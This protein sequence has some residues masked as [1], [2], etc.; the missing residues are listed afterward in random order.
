MKDRF[1]PKAS[2]V[3]FSGC[4]G[5]GQVG[6]VADARKESSVFKRPSSSSMVCRSH[7][8]FVLPESFRKAVSLVL[9]WT[10]GMVLLPARM[11]AQEA[12]QRPVLWASSLLPAVSGTEAASTEAASTGSDTQTNGSLRRTRTVSAA[13]S[14]AADAEMLLVQAQALNASVTGSNLGSQA[15]TGPHPLSTEATKRVGAMFYRPLVGPLPAQ[16]GEGA[17]DQTEASQLKPDGMLLA[18]AERPE[19]ALSSAEANSSRSVGGAPAPATFPAGPGGVDLNAFAPPLS[20]LLFRPAMAAPPQGP[21]TI[22][23]L[24]VFVGYADDVRANPNFPVPWKGSPNT[25][26]IGG[27]ASFDAGAI[28]LDN[29]TSAPIL[30]DGVFVTVPGWTTSDHRDAQGNGIADLW[31]SFTIPPNSTVILT[32]TGEFNFD[33]SDFGVRGCGDTLA[34][35]QPPIP[36]VRVTIAGTPTTFS[37]TA[38]V[39]NTGGFD[40]ACRSNESLQW[41]LIGT[42]GIEN[43]AGHIT[44]APPTSVQPVGANYTATATVTDAG[45]QPTPNVVVNFKVL[46]GPNAGKTGTGTTDAQ[47]NATFSYTSVF[48]GTDILQASV[49]NATGGSIESEQVT[50]TWTSADACP[51]PTQPPDPAQTVLVY[52]GP[53][54]GE[55]NDPLTLAAQLTD[56]NGVPLA[57]RPLS[58][59]FGTQTFSAITDANGVAFVNI[60]AAPAPGAVPF[61]VS[62]AGESNL[63]PAQ[64]ST[65]VTIDREET[66]IR[67]T[68]GTLLGTVVPQQVS[69]VLT[70]PVGGLPIANE[71]VTFRVGTVQAQ[72]V[73]NAQGIATTTI[74]LGADQTSGPTAIQ[75]SFGGDSFYKPS[76]TG[77]PVTV[78]LSTSFVVW[79]GNPGG[80]RLGQDANFWGHSWEDQVIAGNFTANP[81][82]KGFADPV[83]QIHVCEVN[84]GSGGP[85]DDQ[86]WRSKPGNSFPPPLTLPAYIEVIISTAIAKQGSEIFGNIA[87]AAVCQVDSTPAYGPD[88]GKPGFCKLVAVVEDGANVFPQRPAL[89]ASQTQPATVLPGQNFSVTTQVTNNSPAQANSVTASESF[90]GLTPATGTQSLGSILNGAQQTATFQVATPAVPIRGSNESTVAYQQRL[91]TTDG[92]LFT[93]T[94]TITFTDAFGQQFLPIT[95]TSSSR[96][97][98]P[99]LR[100]GISGPACVGPGS[101]IP[102][103][104]TVL[105]VGTAEADNVV[106]SLNMPDGTS[107]TSTI[108]IIPAG[109]SVTT[110]INLVA[111]V[112]SAKQPNE[113]D[114]QYRAR[115][116]AVDGS[117]LIALATVNWQ[118]ALGNNYG[119]IE[120]KIVTTVERVP[121]ITVT[122]Q[123]PPTL[124][125]GQKATLNFSVQNIG[126]GNSSQVL[127]QITNPDGSLVN[128]PAFAL[129]GGQAT[130]FS[131]TFTIPGAAK[132]AGESDA[133][134]QARLAALDNSSIN[135]TTQLRWFDAAAN[136]YGPTSGGFQTTEILPL[137]TV[138]LTGPSNTFST[139]NIN[140]NLRVANIGHADAS[141]FSVIVR[142]PDGSTVNPFPA[143]PIVAGSAAQISIPFGIPQAQPTGQLTA[144]ATL[145]WTDDA[146]NPY[147]P[148]SAP[149]VTANTH[150]NLP[151]VSAGPDQSITTPSTALNGSVTISSL[152]P[153][154]TLVSSWKQISGPAPATFA[155]PSSPVTQITFTA[156]G[157]YVVELTGSVTNTTLP[158]TSSARATISVNAPTGG[159]GGGGG[160][161]GIVNQVLQGQIGQPLVGTV[162]QGQV[163][164]TVANGTTLTSGVL[165]FWPISNPSNVQVLNPNTT[166]TGVIGVFDGTTLQNG[167]YILRLTST[168]ADGT[169]QASLVTL[170][171]IGENKPGRITKTIPDLRVPVA[172]MSITINRIYDSLERGQIGDFGF[173]WKLG[174]NVQ[175]SVDSGNNVS[176]TFN[177]QRQTFFFSAQPGPFPF[178]FV[179]TPSYTPSPGF[180]GALTSDGCSPFTGAQLTCFPGGGTYHPTTFTYNDPYGRVYVFGADGSMKS[181]KDLNG[182]V[183]TFT[184]AG[185]SAGGINVAFARDA[186]GR[187]TQITDLNGKSHTYV[188]D[189]AGNLASVTKPDVTAPV[190]Y[191]YSAD[192]LLLQQTDPR[193][194]STSATYFANGRLQSSTDPLGNV[195]QYSYDLTTN[196]TTTTNPDGGVI[197]Q[198]N[199]SFG[200]P[201]SMTDPLGRTSTFTY[202]A[203]QNMLTMTNPLGKTTTF[204]YDANGNVT[205]VTDPLGQTTTKV[206]DNTG[207]LTRV[208]D[209][210][211]N[212]QTLQYD[213]HGNFLSMSDSLGLLK[214]QTEDSKGNMTS[215]T[216]PN[217]STAQF[218]YDAFGNAVSITD[219]VGFT[220]TRQYDSMGRWTASSDTIHGS[221]IQFQQ[222]AVGNLTQR[223][224]PSG[225]ILTYT[226]DGDRNR[227]AETDQ[228]GNSYSYQYDAANRR[229]QTT[230]PD[231]SSYKRTYNFRGQPLTTTSQSGQTA[232]YTYDLAGQRTQVVIGDGTPDSVTLSFTYDA[233]GRPKTFTDARGNTSTG[234]YDD[235]GQLTSLK[236][237]AGRVTSLT[238]DAG[239]RVTSITHPNGT[240][241]QLTYDV[242]NRPVTN[243]Y[244]DGTKTRYQFD[245]LTLHSKTDEAG[246]ATNYTYDGAGQITS[247]TDALG[248]KTQYTRDAAGRIIGVTD[249]NGHTTSYQ[250]DVNDRIVKEVHPDGSFEQ[251]AYDANNNLTSVRLTDGNINKFTYD[252]MDRLTQI[253]YFDGQIVSFTYTATGKRK[254]ATTSNGTTQ[255]AYD[256]VDRLIRVTQPNGQAVTYTY[257][258]ANNI[259][260]ISSPAGV[261]RYG[262]D[263]VNRLISVTD[264]SG[265]VTTYTYD[266]AGHLVQRVLPNGVITKQTFDSRDRLLSISHQLGTAAPFESF[267]YALGPS[268]NRLSVLEADGSTTNWTYDDVYRLIR[269]TKTQANGTVSSDASYTYDNVD[270]RLTRTV[271]G[272]TTSYQY[273]VLDQLTAAGTAQNSY[274]GRGNLVKVADSNGTTSYTYDAANRLSSVTLPVIGPVATYSY[275][276]DGLL[277]SRASGGTV[278]RYV[279]D[280][281]TPFKDVLYETIDG[282]PNPF[283]AY[284]LAQGSLVQQIG[285]GNTSPSYYLQDGLGSVV[286]LTDPNGV[287]TD[288]YRFDAFGQQTLFTG[289]TMN[290]Y[291]YR[292]QRTDEN[293]NLL[294]LRARY[295]N[296]GVGRFITRDVAPFD[297]TN[298]LD[299]N[300]YN[301]AAAS[302]INDYDPTGYQVVIEYGSISS[303]TSQDAT[304]EGYVVG[305][306]VETLIS[307]AFEVLVANLIASPL[308]NMLVRRKNRPVRN[309]RDFITVALGWVVKS[310]GGI[311]LDVKY[312]RDSVLLPAAA[313]NEEAKK[314]LIA[315][316]DEFEASKR[317]PLLG[318]NVM[319]RDLPGALRNLI[320]DWLDIAIPNIPKK[321]LPQGDKQANHAERQIINESGA[322]DK[323][324]LESVGAS[325]PVCEPCQQAL[326][327][328][329]VRCYG[330]IDHLWH[331]PQW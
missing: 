285:N 102:Y 164:I 98:L 51:T 228:N 121:I 79:G 205:S 3:F 157:T 217:G 71:T 116:A 292:T 220:G 170:N 192:H 270:N 262:Y 172:G 174:T 328:A 49:T 109:G 141:T 11:P 289:T 53:A 63:K 173:G 99:E 145:N 199:N 298:P 243:T 302:P 288:R 92:R 282:A 162:V 47:G 219:H 115:L 327:N 41:R 177:G 229:T 257:D 154:G 62:F 135:F 265:G 247:V 239:G 314:L 82:F 42:S 305:R 319:W 184:P 232:R 133:A 311:G 255:Y 175:V 304:I 39:L 171:V 178:T 37:D 88:P 72:A 16:S 107:A 245:G 122:P 201:I 326:S 24:A 1:C 60:P 100:V 244:A 233:V 324:I 36:T 5:E 188:Y 132:A 166:G 296:P 126:G 101:K 315:K 295:F 300:R 160:G 254:T 258:G 119:Q 80:V 195:T 214:A 283:T 6:S 23:G 186:Q 75:V 310:P 317:F 17:L 185:I 35:G 143:S 86:C 208:T 321:D 235:A 129:Q 52:A 200:N 308:D 191:T 137:L 110:T 251:Y 10:M 8:G 111:P 206:Y 128:I 303:E 246:T 117:N 68:G 118:D 212:V 207:R 197:V 22:A 227:I 236:D 95:V 144:S 64:L 234:S 77:V 318:I 136:T 301:Y 241:E 33:T 211:G 266:V 81:S 105:N 169:T 179:E 163:Q 293:S 290:A 316:A 150:L 146:A 87:A 215:L 38:H 248:N 225:N 61:T 259:T 4:N 148:Q 21:G 277:A 230:F 193:D 59:V 267:R 309:K 120:Q 250:Y 323:S 83:N 90:D 224:D 134:Y 204:T 249:A 73:T 14:T 78:Y 84:A 286:G 142:L 280:Q 48:L 287:E 149:V 93:S 263:A 190:T 40:L 158:L 153:G 322:P 183:L 26:F 187:I 108:A 74:T 56:A 182:N 275:D 66:A 291:R 264:L 202:D 27:G 114:D 34:N 139:N 226:Y 76:L 278:R 330:P 279:W 130:S 161:G 85:L 198:T 189:T 13:A 252:N 46:S 176:F 196:T 221:L 152:P 7:R 18:R 320:P 223:R 274:D 44:L 123:G 272:T 159:G 96:L 284:T 131:S 147:G 45:N 31:G 2:C 268:G 261:I 104:V 55:F 222:D 103:K 155:S 281:L 213:A 218:S 69:A 325:A 168:L 180:H 15:T 97:Q 70:D 331:P 194:N 58:L 231:G 242:R 329:L 67:Y 256:N 271:N 127:L 65:N 57:A 294:Y 307:C 19:L 165:D 113:T 299:L 140:Y 210:L 32:Q 20:R 106:L 9:A 260:S 273:N 91:A 124:L 167:S 181:I 216:L 28:R 151:V 240:Q 156:N 112:I 50:T 138:T 54:S 209:P 29:N 238:Y 89:I 306:W 269:E 94:G 25:T 43:Q 125:P 203:N 12:G 237:A 313:R 276:A 30:I 297:L 253:T 312:G